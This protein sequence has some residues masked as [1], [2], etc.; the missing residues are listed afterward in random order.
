ME[1]SPISNPNEHTHTPEENDNGNIPI[2]YPEDS[3]S[4]VGT[5]EGGEEVVNDEEEFSDA[6]K[7]W[8]QLDDEIKALGRAARLRRKEKKDITG[9][10]V[11]IMDEIAIDNIKGRDGILTVTRTQAKVPLTKENIRKTLS[12]K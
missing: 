10:I 6:V 7:R 8:F 1:Q 3:A 9:R 12:K 5:G 2:I 11:E 4:Q